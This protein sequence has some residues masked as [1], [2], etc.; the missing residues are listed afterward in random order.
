MSSKIRVWAAVKGPDGTIQCSVED[1]ESVPN[2]EAWLDQPDFR[3]MRMVAWSPDMLGA[4]IDEQRSCSRV[5]VCAPG[6]PCAACTEAAEKW[7]VEWER[8]NQKRYWMA[9]QEPEGH[10]GWTHEHWCHHRHKKKDAALACA[11]KLGF[12]KV[13]EFN[14]LGK[15]TQRAEVGA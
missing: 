7:W 9:S 2:G 3:V 13:Y 1:Y 12:P 11:A 6:R 5:N 15:R 10:K 4:L 8:R 14:G